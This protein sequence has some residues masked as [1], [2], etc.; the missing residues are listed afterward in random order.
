[1]SEEDLGG[2]DA[3]MGP[4]SWVALA[5]LLIVILAVALGI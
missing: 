2:P 5:A 3:T 1:M 4:W